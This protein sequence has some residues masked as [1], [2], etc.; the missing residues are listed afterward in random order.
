MKFVIHQPRIEVRE[1]DLP[2]LPEATDQ[3]VLAQAATAAPESV[4]VVDAG[5]AFVH[6]RGG[7][8]VERAGQM[9]ADAR[10]AE[11]AAMAAAKQVAL[12]ALDAG[13]KSERALA[14]TLGVDRNT[15]RAWRG[16]NGA[17]AHSGVGASR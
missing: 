6:L 8:E 9:L 4:S 2:M 10:A 11:D 7:D 14:A 17:A 12:A 15:I 3:Q 1:Y 16:K 13:T 5:S